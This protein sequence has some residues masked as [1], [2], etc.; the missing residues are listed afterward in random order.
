[1]ET[2]TDWNGRSCLL[3]DTGA[4]G[5]TIELNAVQ[6]SNPEM[7]KRV[8]NTIRALVDKAKT[9]LFLSTITVLEAILIAY[10]N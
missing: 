10:Q 4:L 2:I 1:M 9:L 5:S 7:Q 8:A 3:A 6:R